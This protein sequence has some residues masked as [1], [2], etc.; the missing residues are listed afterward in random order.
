MA[1]YRKIRPR[2]RPAALGRVKPLACDFPTS[3]ERS[4]AAI[5]FVQFYARPRPSPVVQL[6]RK[7]TPCFVGTDF[8]MRMG[9]AQRQRS[10]VRRHK[11]CDVE[12]LPR[13][14]PLNAGLGVKAHHLLGELATQVAAVETPDPRFA[15]ST[16]APVGPA[17]SVCMTVGA[18]TLGSQLPN[19]VPAFRPQDGLGLG[20]PAATALIGLREVRTLGRI[21]L[22]RFYGERNSYPRTTVCD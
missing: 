21:T 14:I 10:G 2:R 18:R 9:G 22:H 3:A 5:G 20:R 13:R 1:A 19:V 17:R 7:R 4:S 16:L 12:A 8:G 15:N 11:R 6:S